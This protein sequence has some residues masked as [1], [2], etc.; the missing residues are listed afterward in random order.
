MIY[1]INVFAYALCISVV[2]VL[3]LQIIYLLIYVHALLFV[4]MHKQIMFQM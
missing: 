2:F 4:D 3:S 1:E